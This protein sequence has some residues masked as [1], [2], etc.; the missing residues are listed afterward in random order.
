MSQ[1]EYGEDIGIFEFADK[2]M[3]TCRRLRLNK[4]IR[5][6]IYRRHSM[7]KKDVITKMMSDEVTVNL[8]IYCMFT[9]DVS[10]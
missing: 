4:N 3:K 2:I 8:N 9:K 1:T 5:R 10:V 7:K 6:L